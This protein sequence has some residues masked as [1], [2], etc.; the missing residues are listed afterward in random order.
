[1]AK[2]MNNTQTKEA[3]MKEIMRLSFVTLE[4]NLYLDGHPTNKKALAYFKRYNEM[5]KAKKKEYEQM[6]GP[7]TADGNVSDK[8]WLWST[9]KWPWQMED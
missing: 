9:Q 5:L 6:Y 8:E 4:T 7:L 3:L 2:E 1:M